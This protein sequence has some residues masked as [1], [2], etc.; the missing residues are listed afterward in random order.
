MTRGD[1]V[2]SPEVRRE[3]AIHERSIPFLDGT[4]PLQVQRW[5]EWWWTPVV[6]AGIGGAALFLYYCFEVWEFFW[7]QNFVVFLIMLLSFGAIILLP[8][9]TFFGF[10]RRNEPQLP[11]H[12]MLGTVTKLGYAANRSTRSTSVSFQSPHGPRVEAQLTTIQG[13]L[14]KGQRVAVLYYGDIVVDLL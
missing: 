2:V 6:L 7:A 1:I 13:D 8:F 9:A 11:S 14:K 4:G 5:R 3:H 10:R 12:V